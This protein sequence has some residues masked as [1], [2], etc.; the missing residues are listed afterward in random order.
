MEEWKMKRKPLSAS[1]VTGAIALVFLIIGY[2]VAVFIH[3]AAVTRIEANR[4]HPDTVYVYVNET[5]GQAGGDERRKRPFPE[6]LPG[7]GCEATRRKG[8]LPPLR[9]LCVITPSTVR[10]WRQ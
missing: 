6:H 10:L 5:P 7:Q 9:A 1:F 8:S 3:K 4:D 2:E